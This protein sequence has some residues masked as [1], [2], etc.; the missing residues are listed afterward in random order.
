MP[1]EIEKVNG[2]YFVKVID[3]GRRLSKKPIPL[4]RA[5]AQIA[6][7]H[8]N[9]AEGTKEVSANPTAAMA[10]GPGGMLSVA[11]MSGTLTTTG[12]GMVGSGKKKRSKKVKETSETEKAV[13][14]PKRIEGP[15]QGNIEGLSIHLAHQIGGDP[16]FFTKCVSSAVLDRT[17]KYLG[18]PYNEEEKNGICAKAHKLVTG[19]WPGQHRSKKYAN[20]GSTIIN[21][22]KEKRIEEQRV[23]EIE[24]ED[25][26]DCKELGEIGERAVAVAGNESVITVYK[27]NDSGKY[28]WVLFSSNAFQD[29]DHEIVSTKALEADVD[30]ADTDGDYGPLRWWHV[31]GAD[32]GDTDFNMMH[33]RILVE[34]G[35]FRNEKLGAKFKELA[36]DLQASIGFNHPASE[37]D[38]NGIFHNIRRFER[39]LLPRG[40][41]S[42]G[43]TAFSVKGVSMATKE[44][45]L[46]KLYD[47]LG[48]DAADIIKNAE[49]TE[50]AAV[51]AGIAFKE[52]KDAADKF[53]P[54]E[55]FEPETTKAGKH[56]KPVLPEA[57]EE[58]DEDQ[59]EP[60]KAEE[61]DDEDQSE[62]SEAEDEDEEDQSEPGKS[63]EDDEDD[64]EDDEDEDE[65]DQSEPGPAAKVGK[66]RLFN[67]PE[68]KK[69]FS[70]M[71][72]REEELGK[73]SKK[74]KKNAPTGSFDP[75]STSNPTLAAG[76]LG[77]TEF[78]GVAPRSSEKTTEKDQHIHVHLGGEDSAASSSEQ[79][80]AAAD[81]EKKV[82]LGNVPPKPGKAAPGKAAPVAEA[83]QV[84]N[85]D[86]EA[87]PGDE[88]AD[89]QESGSDVIGNMT[90]DEFGDLLADALA[91]ALAP[92]LRNIKEAK[93]QITSVRKELTEFKEHQNTVST[94]EVDKR[95]V[96]L[97]KSAREALRKIKELEGDI[98]AGA[99]PYIASQS[100]DTI[101][102]DERQ[103]EFAPPAP[104]PLSNF[105][106][107]VTGGNR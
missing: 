36:P 104:D 32:I 70:E 30:R 53:D 19:I 59:S 31:K 71:P 64:E 38:G 1:Y 55:H 69:K 94:K 81:G 56:S 37:P 60:G 4:A 46:A 80:P 50:K 2:G 10:H 15:G 99:K 89:Q 67:A 95:M 5:K 82:K 68:L 47:L 74:S 26:K 65:E 106:N 20:M 66:S 75:K 11:G 102:S 3:T 83:E 27:D 88:Q 28:R 24:C 73:K 45:K 48:D 52:S 33:G 12:P 58:D 105:M 14:K 79:A 84:D 8:A 34:S 18:R 57:E 29:S 51:E 16:H 77:F 6:A 41:A 7:L 63:M 86:E 23:T 107:F 21:M 87:Q 49:S 90:M 97:E 62:P 17:V 101:L 61:E 13:R 22:K 42:N 40:F 96:S 78:L 35:T 25:C 54:D 43:L 76:L 98:P 72:A 91:T 39:S 92:Y 9:S 85:A 100:D 103:K 44:E 93:D